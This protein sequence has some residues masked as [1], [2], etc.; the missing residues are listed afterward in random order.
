MA[1]SV[2]TSKKAGVGQSRT[3]TKATGYQSALAGFSTS[4]SSIRKQ[5]ITDQAAQIDYEIEIG[6]K[7]IPEKVAL[8]ESYLSQLTTD[9]TEW[10]RVSTKIQNLKDQA[11]TTD[12]AIVKKMYS[13]GQITSDDYYQF[14]KERVA[15]SGISSQEKTSRT[16]ELQSFEKEVKDGN[17]DDLIRSSALQE[18]LGIISSLER[19]EIISKAY[20][21][22]T[23]PSRQRTLQAQMIAQERRVVDSDL[24]LKELQIRKGIQ[25]GTATTGDLLAVQ[26]RRVQLAATPTETLQAE[27]TYQNTLDKYNG[28][29]K[30]L[31]EKGSKAIKTQALTEVGGIDKKIEQAKREGDITTIALLYRTK[32]QKI[33]EY[34]ANPNVTDE[35]RIVTKFLDFSEKVLG[36]QI[37][38]DTFEVTDVTPAESEDYNITRVTD[39]INNPGSSGLLKVYGA[40]GGVTGY[41][42]VRGTQVGLDENGVMTY[43]YG[44]NNIYVRN[45][46]QQFT[47]ANGQIQTFEVPELVQ[48]KEVPL[49]VTL[50][51]NND[52]KFTGQSV[53]LGQQQNADGQLVDQIGYIVEGKKAGDYIGMTPI[54]GQPD[55]YVYESPTGLPPVKN[56]L[57]KRPEALGGFIQTAANVQN[58]IT[59][60][61]FGVLPQVPGAILET[62]A[63][64]YVANV[65][66]IEQDSTQRALISGLNTGGFT[67]DSQA[68]LSGLTNGGIT[69]G[70]QKA[71]QDAQLPQIQMPD[72]NKMF[73]S[74]SAGV[75]SQL[76]SSINTPKMNIETQMSGYQSAAQKAINTATSAAVGA[77][78]TI[79]GLADKAKAAGTDIYNKITSGISSLFK[80]N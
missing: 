63:K 17:T 57:I 13:V 65:P 73:N 21:N 44:N 35:D 2:Q 40:D 34:M 47:D 72:F 14:L 48:S 53:V 11:S 46:T 80:W 76:M 42:L 15:E 43:S 71:M 32:S 70:I 30:S 18:S 64:G 9:T 4:I 62:M 77:T 39:A 29:L 60:F 59:K 31:Y 68:F 66:G 38:P 78:G 67:K 20:S 49:G 45:K 74:I 51:G 28:E 22:E 27:I 6:S 36:K 75:A 25:V 10:Y 23:D 5:L 54:P 24:D 1:Y 37:D 58:T 55:R 19:Y 41:K 12:T 50:P 69:Q 7:S 33:A 52:V 8:Y 56:D 79:S 16:L 3:R 26:A 61:G